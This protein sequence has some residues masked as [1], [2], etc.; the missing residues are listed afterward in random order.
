[1][2]SPDREM[3]GLTPNDIVAQILQKIEVPR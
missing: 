2:L 1:M 3:E